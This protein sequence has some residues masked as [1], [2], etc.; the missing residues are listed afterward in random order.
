MYFQNMFALCAVIL[1]S[2]SVCMALHL[3][4]L[5]TENI[6]IQNILL[7]SLLWTMIVLVQR[8]ISMQIKSPRAARRAP[9]NSTE[10]YLM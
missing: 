4:V 3:S 10:K 5:L 7:S 8:N 9:S 1:S 6:F 2:L